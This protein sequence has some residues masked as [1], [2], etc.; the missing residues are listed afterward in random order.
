MST[1]RKEPLAIE[2]FVSRKKKSFILTTSMVY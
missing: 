1:T 2:D